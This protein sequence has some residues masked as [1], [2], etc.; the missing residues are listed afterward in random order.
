MLPSPVVL[1]NGKGR[2]V[3]PNPL[4]ADLMASGIANRISFLQDH[5]LEPDA[6]ILTA[7]ARL[8]REMG[9]LAN[10]VRMS[11]EFLEGDRVWNT[12]EPQQREYASA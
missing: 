6:E 12:V 3:Y 2:I 11:I 9:E 4:V 7:L 1:R 8:E 5:H 10:A